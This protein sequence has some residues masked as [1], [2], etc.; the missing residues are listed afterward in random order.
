MSY[1]RYHPRSELPPVASVDLDDFLKEFSSE[2]QHVEFK[3]GI[4]AK[5]LCEAA[6]AFFNA[7][8]GV[9]LVGYDERHGLVDRPDPADDIR[10]VHDAL[11]SVHNPGHFVCRELS[12]GETRL[13]VVSFARRENGFAQ[14]GDGSVRQRQGASNQKLIGPALSRFQMSRSFVVYETTPTP[15]PFSDVTVDALVDTVKVYDLAD[16]S[17]A[18]FEDAGLAA[19]VEGAYRL[20]VAGA[21]IML[22]DIEDVLGRAGIEFRRHG[23][24]EG[25]PDKRVTITGTVRE[26]TE[27]A[28][29]LVNDELGYRSVYIGP[30][31][32]DLPR[33]P[34]SVVR[35]TIANAVAHRSYEY[36]GTW[37]LVSLYPNRLV[38]E[39]PGLLPEPVTVENIRSR[40]AARNPVVLKYLRRC[41]LAE[42]LGQ[43]VALMEDGMLG[44]LLEKPEYVEASASFRV[45]LWLDGLFTP[46]ERGWIRELTTVRRIDPLDA[47]LV[48]LARRHGRLTNRLVRDALDCDREQA[49]AMLQ[50]LRAADVLVQAGQRGGVTYTLHEDLRAPANRVLS[51]EEERLAVLHLAERGP[52]RNEDLRR[53]LGIDRSRALRLLGALVEEGSLVRE[54]ERR[55]TRYRLPS[56]RG[57]S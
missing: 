51:D 4:Q 22:T 50:R 55:G 49:V 27:R 29:T 35:E 5:A 30:R 32:Y 38:V 25:Q 26:V 1:P 23:F 57:S 19:L 2:N 12:V 11:S 14:L 40:Q 37:T 42:D 41:G 44:D 15:F 33:L 46:E 53:R 31:R 43:G 10:R 56:S 28:Q 52:V 3:R 18:S 54:G 17:A 24:D 20:T 45:T 34:E 9:L 21:L 36:R 8:G 7:D 13:V 39:S 16:D 47:R 6:V 48:V